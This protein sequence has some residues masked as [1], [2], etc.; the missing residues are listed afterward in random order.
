MLR[1]LK[2][3]KL[4]R[5]LV[6]EDKEDASLYETDWIPKNEI[7]SALKETLV[8]QR[9]LP[10]GAKDLIRRQLISTGKLELIEFRASAMAISPFR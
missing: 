9:W 8:S 4:I 6:I 5:W 2:P 7:V 10:D 1:L 3:E